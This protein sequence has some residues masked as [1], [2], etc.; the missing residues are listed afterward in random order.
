MRRSRFLPLVLL[1]VLLNSCALLIGEPEPI[2]TIVHRTVRPGDVLR[3]RD[4]DSPEPP[5][6]VMTVDRVGDVVVPDLGTT[7]PVAGYT[8]EDVEAVLASFSDSAE[9]RIAVEILP[10]RSRFWLYGEVGRGGRRALRPGTTVTQAVAG[11]KPRS[12]RA[13][14]GAVRI[15]RGP[16]GP[17]ELIVDLAAAGEDPDL[18]LE[19]MDGDVLLVLPRGAGRATVLGMN[20]H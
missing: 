2:P 10:P 4:M 9:R 12:D 16:P 8:A 11:S 19:V 3:V 13:D 14:L 5:L 6:A 7:L 20:T 1:S 15:L 17:A 18:D